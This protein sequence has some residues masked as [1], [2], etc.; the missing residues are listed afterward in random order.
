MINRVYSHISR[1]RAE[2]IEKLRY[3]YASTKKYRVDKC[4]ICGGNRFVTLSHV[5][6]YGFRATAQACSKCSL[7]FLN[8][9]MTLGEYSMFYE[10]VYRPLVSAYHGRLIDRNTIQGE[11]VVYS[12][13]LADLIEPWVEER[14][15]QRM[16]DIGGS[17]G[18]VSAELLKRFGKIDATILDPAAHELDVA[19]QLGMKTVAGFVEDFDPQGEVFDLVIL[20]QTADHLLDPAKVFSRIRN[21]LSQ[22]G[23]FFVDI[24]DFRAAYLRQDSIEGA[25]KIDHPYYFTELSI[26]CLLKKS[27]FDIL[28][29]CYAEDHLHIGYVCEVSRGVGSIELDENKVSES[30]VEIRRIQNYGRN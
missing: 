25:I 22:K 27:G 14:S 20:C 4:N 21:I 3:D 6:R 26:E 19:N 9:V 15:I 10:E 12:H 11:Q 1:E 24:V 18:V 2:R 7:V 30:F 16:L 8:P 29:K 5:D 13:A 17:T 28:H 23:L